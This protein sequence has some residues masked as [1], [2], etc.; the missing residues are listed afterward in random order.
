[1]KQCARQPTNAVVGFPAN[2]LRAQL[3][4]DIFP[5]PSGPKQCIV[6]H[7]AHNHCSLFLRATV[8]RGIACRM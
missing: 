3:A 2:R 1:M 5:Q 7:T 6:R 4:R 8:F